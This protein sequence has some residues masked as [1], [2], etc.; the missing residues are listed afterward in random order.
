MHTGIRQRHVAIPWTEE[1]DKNGKLRNVEIQ[2][3]Y[4]PPVYE[5]RGKRYVVVREQK[6][7]KQARVLAE[8]MQATVVIP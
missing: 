8:E 7:V 5:H 1:K 4:V 6:Q 2:E 3:S